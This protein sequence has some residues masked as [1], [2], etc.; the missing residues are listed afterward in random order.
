L[1]VRV[2]IGRPGEEDAAAYVLAAPAGAEAEALR[3]AEARAAEA[4]RAVLAD[5]PVA[6]MNR[7]NP[8]PAEAPPAGGEGTGTR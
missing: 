4:V 5:G 6:A 7:F 2:G 3:A 1:R 8:W